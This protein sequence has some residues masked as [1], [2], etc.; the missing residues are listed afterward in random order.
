MRMVEA[1]F[2]RELKANGI[3]YVGP[4]SMLLSVEYVPFKSSSGIF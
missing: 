1:L 3:F 2:P 4:N